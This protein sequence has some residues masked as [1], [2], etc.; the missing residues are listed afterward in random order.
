MIHLKSHGKSPSF[1]VQSWFNPPDFSTGKQLVPGMTNCQ[2]SWWKNRWCSGPWGATW[3]TLYLFF[4]ETPCT[5]IVK[6]YK[7]IQRK[8]EDFLQ[9]T[10]SRPKDLLLVWLDWRHSFPKNSTGLDAT[11]LNGT[12]WVSMGFHGGLVGPN[13]ALQVVV[14]AESL[15][16]IRTWETWLVSSYRVQLSGGKKHVLLWGRTS[17]K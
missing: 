11:G 1:L 3:G 10:K 5:N 12:P 14:A 13:H 8:Y 6:S 17:E 15:C 16:N 2:C 9:H 7:R 4:R